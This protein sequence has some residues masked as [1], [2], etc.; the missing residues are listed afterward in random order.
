MVIGYLYEY[1]SIYRMIKKNDFPLKVRT[2]VLA[3]STLEVCEH[4]G[5]TVNCWLT[6]SYAYN[7]ET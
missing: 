4:K 1:L 3:R 7:I 2:E 5:V 6:I